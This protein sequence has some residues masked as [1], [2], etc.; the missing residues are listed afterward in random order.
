MAPTTYYGPTAEQAAYS[1]AHAFPGRVPALAKLLRVNAAVLGNQINPHAESHKLGLGTAV[2]MTKAAQDFRILYAFAGDCDHGTFRLPDLSGVS[3][4][5]LL[6]MV[7][8]GQMEVGE[9][10][11]LLRTAL[12][13]GRID[14]KEMRGLDEQCRRILMAY[15]TLLQRLGGLAD[16]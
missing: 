16:G 15:W 5:A 6:D 14:R 3:D 12:A 8:E 11:R 7:L 4:E 1:V 13:D 9:F 2:A 10:G